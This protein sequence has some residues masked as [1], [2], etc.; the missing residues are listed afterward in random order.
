MFPLKKKAKLVVGKNVFGDDDDDD[1]AERKSAAVAGDVVAADAEVD[2]PLDAFM[3]EVHDNLAK[4]ADRVAEAPAAGG[5]GDQDEQKKKK[6]R[7]SRVDLDEDEDNVASFLE[8]RRR[9]GSERTQ[10]STSATAGAEEDW[11]KKNELLKPV[12]HTLIEYG[13]FNKDFYQPH[14]SLQN[15]SWNDLNHKRRCVC[16][17]ER[18]R[19]TRKNHS[20]Q[21]AFHSIVL[22]LTSVC[23]TISK[24]L[25]LESRWFGFAQSN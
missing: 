23:F 8:S 9:S 1:G 20:Q 13:S 21:S 7:D 5:G 17:C 16:V 11:R 10:T 2:D 12:D 15:L 22:C 18:E 6:R 4:E 19:V 25:E 14:P 24:G 3:A